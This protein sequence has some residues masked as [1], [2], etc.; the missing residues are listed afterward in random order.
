MLFL[1]I[2]L[3]IKVLTTDVITVFQSRAKITKPVRN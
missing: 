1:F 3:S 2:G